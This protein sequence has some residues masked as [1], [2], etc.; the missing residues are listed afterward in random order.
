MKINEQG[1]NL[2]GRIIAIQVI[3]LI[4]CIAFP[5]VVLWLPR[6]TGLLD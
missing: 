3:G 6:V 5:G 4:L 2:G 1:Q